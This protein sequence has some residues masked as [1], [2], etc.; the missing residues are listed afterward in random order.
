M[1]SLCRLPKK[2][3]DHWETVSCLGQYTRKVAQLQLRTHRLLHSLPGTDMSNLNVK[4]DL[5]RSKSIFL[6][7]PS[8]LEEIS[9]KLTD[10]IMYMKEVLPSLRE[11]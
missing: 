8:V 4:H 2:H 5:Q 1:K 7:W 11:K 6:P 9:S 10:L 3:W